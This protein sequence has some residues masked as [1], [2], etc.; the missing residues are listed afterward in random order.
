MSTSLEPKPYFFCKCLLK[1]ARL[2]IY[3]NRTYFLGKKNYLQWGF[4]DVRITNDMYD[5]KSKEYKEKQQ[6]LF[7]QMEEHSKADENFYFL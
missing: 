7:I 2:S 4:F 1:V 3:L 5:K 6:D